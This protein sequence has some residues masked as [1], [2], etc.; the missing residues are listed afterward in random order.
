MN[1][2]IQNNAIQKN[3][4]D[5]KRNGRSIKNIK[6][7]EMEDNNQENNIIPES[8]EIL[9]IKVRHKRSIKNTKKIAI[10]INSEKNQNQLSNDI[11]NKAIIHKKKRSIKNNNNRLLKKILFIILFIVSFF[12]LCT[13]LFLI[14]Y[15]FLFKKNDKIGEEYQKE[16]LII[17]INYTEN[18]FLKFRS[19]KTITLSADVDKKNENSTQKLT[20]FLDFFFI[21]RNK[22]NELD[23][24]KTYIKNIYTGY[25]GILNATINNGTNDMMIIYDEN[26]NKY[27]KENEI[28]KNLRNLD[29]EGEPD[30]DYVQDS[31][32]NCF[33][34]IEFYENG[35]IINIFIPDDF[36]TS[37]MIYLNNIIKLIIPKISP[38]LYSKNIEE[39]IKD[40]NLDNLNNLDEI[41]Y[42]N[43]KAESNNLTDNEIDDDEENEEEE[44]NEDGNYEEEEK[45]NN[46]YNKIFENITLIDDFQ[47]ENIVEKIW[48]IIWKKIIL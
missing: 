20:Q 24:N 39:Q 38:N 21:I 28:N 40:L 25:I 4:E 43:E 13:L 46:E 29:G 16:N 12:V 17:K 34:K 22:N 14:V 27:M 2:D 18:I 37:N 35:E 15:L 47:Q 30:L 10:D 7:Q 33:I 32:K 26:I 9:T 6:F 23:P 19:T 44:D 11:L 45:Q 5:N 1:N 48:K 3:D 41:E 36:H 42:E 8:N 31:D